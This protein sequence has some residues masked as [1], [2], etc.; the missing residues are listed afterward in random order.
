[1]K[2]VFIPLAIVLL[3]LSITSSVVNTTVE[4]LNKAL[5]TVLEI[6]TILFSSS[7]AFIFSVHLSSNKVSNIN[8]DSFKGNNVGGDFV[9]DQSTS[10]YQAKEKD[11]EL[12]P[13]LHRL[14]DVIENKHREN[15]DNIQNN[16]EEKMAN[17]DAPVKQPNED[18]MYR[19]V[20]SGRTISDKDIQKVWA[21]LYI[22]EAVNPSSVSFRTLEIVKNL[23]FYEMNLFIKVLDYCLKI[24]NSGYVPNDICKDV[25]SLLDITRLGDIG[26]LKSETTLSWTPTFESD[27]TTR[28]LTGDNLIF[29]INNSSKDIK[30]RIPVYILTDAGVQLA[31]A[32][33][34]WITDDNVIKFA[35]YLKNKY[36]SLEI[37]SHKIISINDDGDIQYNSDDMLK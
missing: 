23:T 19:Y 24:V 25:L 15:I 12:V 16:I 8:D 35:K 10:I 4:E 20:E 29:L 34:H 9:I 33:N 37:T 32:I 31:S 6:L 18:F 11:E 30:A 36:N 28:L 1:M 3:L 2:K 13:A 5:H 26:L 22:K 27:R 17:V 7:S 14:A 21:D